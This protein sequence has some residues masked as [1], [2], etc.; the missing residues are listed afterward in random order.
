MHGHL[1]SLRERH[2]NTIHY[3]IRAKPSPHRCATQVPSPRPHRRG[4]RPPGA[5]GAQAHCSSEHAGHPPA[6][7]A[8]P[9][10]PTPRIPH[11]QNSAATAQPPQPR[12]RRGRSQRGR[13][14]A[15]PR[16]LAGAEGRCQAGGCPR[17]SAVRPDRSPEE[18]A[19]RPPA[20]RR[21]HEVSGPRPVPGW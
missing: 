11:S 8:P 17:G 14:G 18:P 2:V 5:S 12:W 13:L 20:P 10:A 21:R 19:D 15:G 4:P 7:P 16:R 9:P 6:A 3:Q 1:P